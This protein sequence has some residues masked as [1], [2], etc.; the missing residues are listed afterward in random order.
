MLVWALFFVSLTT[1]ILVAHSFE[2]SA[3]RRV[4]DTRY[5]RVDLANT[6]AESGLTDATAYLRRQTVQPVTTFA[7]QLDLASD[8]PVNDTSDPGVG[9]VRDFEVNGNLWGRYEVRNDE[10]IDVSVHYG[11]PPGTVWDVGARGYLYEIQ[12]P[13]RAYDQA[14]NRVISTQAV[15]TEVRGMNLNLPTDTAIVVEDPSQVDM[16]GNGTIDG[17]GGPAVAY[18][19]P[20]IP[21]PLPIFDISISGSPI[22][23]SI[24][25]LDLSVDSI[26]GMRED[27]LRNLADLVLHSPRQLIG[28]RL[29]DQAVYVPS[30]LDLTPGGL[31]LRGRMLLIVDGNLTAVDGNASNFAGVVYVKGD[32]VIEG[33]FTF[34]G[35]MIVHGLFKIGGSADTV[36]IKSDPA[37]VTAL[38]TSLSQYRISRDKRPAAPSGAFAAPSDL[39]TTLR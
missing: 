32:A 14:P 37:T 22:G 8:P 15:R 20:G 27:K 2:M 9:L 33:P 4:M 29:N 30:D 36:V 39:T 23:V 21:L 18:K 38:Q 1:G 5:R 26:F 12:D 19:D 11:E 13:S 35:T 16:R 17:S 28:R 7:P 34:V 6:I 10:T 25:G 3:N 31:S 24:L